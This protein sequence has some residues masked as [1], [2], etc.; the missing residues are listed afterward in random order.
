MTMLLPLANQPYLGSYH[1][2]Y[3][4]LNLG[5]RTLTLD[6]LTLGSYPT[7]PYLTVSYPFF[8]LTI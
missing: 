1:R 3:P 7:L 2:L 4:R 8:T 5:T 6:Y